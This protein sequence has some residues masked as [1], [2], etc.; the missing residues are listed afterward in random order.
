MLETY[1]GRKQDLKKNKGLSDYGVMKRTSVFMIHEKK[2][3]KKKRYLPMQ[4]N[5]TTRNFRSI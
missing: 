2:G 1:S 3:I 5:R 4:V